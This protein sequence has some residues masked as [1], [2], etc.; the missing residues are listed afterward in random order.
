MAKSLFE[1][2]KIV[3]YANN[4]ELI[5]GG[6]AGASVPP[7]QVPATR[8]IPKTQA[9]PASAQQVSAPAPVPVAPPAPAPTPAPPAPERE[10]RAF[11]FDGATELTGSFSTKGGSKFK[12][13]TVHCTV[14]PGWG[15]TETGSFTVF[16]I[17]NPTDNNDYK[18][19]FEFTR[20]S[21][22]GGYQ[23]NIVVKFSSGS[24]YQTR[25]I[26]NPLSPNFYSGSVGF[27]FYQMSFGAAAMLSTIRVGK[28]TY[29][30]TNDTVV[31][32][33][34]SSTG[35]FA[36]GQLTL[37]PDDYDMTVGGLNSGSN[38]YFKGEIANLAVSKNTFA[39]LGSTM[40]RNIEDYSTVDI[41]YKFEG[42]LLASKGGQ[43]LG[44]AGTETYVS[45]SI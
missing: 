44:V 21:G 39:A 4:Q 22:S 41:A 8:S 30:P 28:N 32:S 43:N 6:L 18:R 34:T 16:S 35:V 37:N 7:R 25:T 33:T 27:K 45:S 31:G 14:R 24:E 3:R 40:P 5:E 19:S 2:K 29:Y 9:I 23:D 12:Y 38:G 11:S 10:T 17:N 15:S 1:P 13:G 26:K 36:A 42:T 20:T